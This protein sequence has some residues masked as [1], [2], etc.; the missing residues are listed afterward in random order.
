[1]NDIVL[2]KNLGNTLLYWDK[3]PELLITSVECLE[4][5]GTPLVVSSMNRTQQRDFYQS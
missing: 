2:G 1:M 3:G 4:S 5:L